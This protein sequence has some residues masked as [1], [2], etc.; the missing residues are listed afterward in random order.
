MRLIIH[1]EN[2][3]IF[4]AQPKLLCLSQCRINFIFGLFVDFII[5]F[6]PPKKYSI[7][8]LRESMKISILR[9]DS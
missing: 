7:E 8:S 1:G 4:L 5:K 3:T 6:M 2:E 9:L